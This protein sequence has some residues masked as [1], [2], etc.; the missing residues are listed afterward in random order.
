VTATDDLYLSD[1]L[2]LCVTCSQPIKATI[3]TERWVKVEWIS[4]D[5]ECRECVRKAKEDERGQ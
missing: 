4:P 3:T 5:G 1:V 2:L